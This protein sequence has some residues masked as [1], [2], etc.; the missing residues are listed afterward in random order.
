MD[1]GNGRFGGKRNSLGWNWVSW[2][3]VWLV[4]WLVWWVVLRCSEWIIDHGTLSQ[5]VGLWA[6]H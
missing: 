6:N 2:V 3:G 1:R 4:G 5:A